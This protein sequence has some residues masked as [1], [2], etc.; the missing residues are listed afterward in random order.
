M[1][2]GHQ[3]KQDLCAA[4]VAWEHPSGGQEG[5]EPL[6]TINIEWKNTVLAFLEACGTTGEAKFGGGT[7]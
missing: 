1:C 4:K 3:N 7:H 6:K 2:S 5:Q